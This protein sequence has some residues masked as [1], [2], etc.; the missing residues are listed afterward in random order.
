M[1]NPFNTTTQADEV[2]TQSTDVS[3]GNPFDTQLNDNVHRY[4]VDPI[5]AAASDVVGGA[6]ATVTDIGTSLWNS[7]PLTPNVSTQDVLS[8]VS[9][10]ALRVYNENPDTINTL[11]FIGG[12]LLPMS[13]ATKGMGAMRAGIKGVNW[14]SAAGREADLARVATLFDQA[15]ESTAEYRNLTRSIYAK[16]AVNQAIDA[17][18]AEAAFV[19]MYNAHP[20]MEDYLKDP[21]QNFTLS[22]LIGG[23]LGAGVGAIADRFVLKDITGSVAET[24]FNSVNEAMRAITPDMTN[25]VKLQSYDLNVKNLQDVIDARKE[26]G[27]DKFNDLTYQIADQVQNSI[28]AEQA[29]L[30]DEMVSP[31]IKALPKEERDVIMQKIIQSPEMFGADNFR[32]LTDKEITASGVVKPPKNQLE[33]QPSFV[34]NTS[35]KGPTV[36]VPK[37]AVYY[38][39]LGLYGTKQDAVHYAGASVFGKTKEQLAKELP[40][41]YGK[42]PNYDSNLELLA[43]GSADAQAEQIAAW[44]RVKQMSVKE[45]SKLNISETDAVLQNAVL[46]RLLT[47]PEAAGLAVRVSDNSPVLKKIIETHTERLV[48]DGKLSASEVAASGPDAAY[49]NKVRSF[50]DGDK[51]NTFRPSDPDALDQINRW[52]AGGGVQELR[53]ASVDYFAIKYGG[54]AKSGASTVAA[55]N[56]AKLYEAPESI[57]LRNKYRELADAGGN[58]YLYRGWKTND[59][60]GHAPVESYSAT[61]EKAKQFGHVK[62]Y[63]VNVDD[64]IAGFKDVGPGENNAEILVRAGAR[65]VE[66]HLDAK[67]LLAFKKAQQQEAGK[68]TT[69]TT[70]TISADSAGTS[71]VD[72]QGLSKIYIANKQDAID[73]LLNQGMPIQSIALKT[74]TDPDVVNAWAHARQN[75]DSLESLI[76]PNQSPISFLNKI[77][78]Y[79]DIDNVLKSSNQPIVMSGNLRKNAAYVDNHVALDKHEMRSLNREFLYRTMLSSNNS[80]VQAMAD[81]FYSPEGFGPALDVI[82]AKLGKVNNELAGNGFINSFDFF[83][84]NMAE[85]GPATSAIGKQIQNIANGYIKQVVAPI[86]NAMVA[87]QKDPAALVEFSVFHNL[88]ASLKG[89]RGFDKDGY[90]VQ[91]VEKQ[92]EDGTTGQVLERVK[93]QGNDYKVVTQEARDL[94]QAIQDQSAGLRDLSNTLRKATGAP[95]ISD[96]GLWIPSFNPVDKFIAYV[97]DTVT[98]TTKLL[99]GKTEAELDN[100]VKAYHGYLKETGQADTVRIISNKT[101]Q[102]NWNILNGR[103]DPI[104]MERA[105]IGLQKT[106][107]SAAAIVKPDIKLLGEIAAGYEHY[108]TAQ[109]RNLADI[110]MHEITEGLQR[111]SAYNKRNFTSQPLSDVKKAIQQPKDAAAIMRNVLLGSPNLGEYAGWQWLNKGFETTIAVA[112]NSLNQVWNSTVKP[113]TKGIFGGK[114]ELDLAGIKK[115]DFEEFTKELNSRGIQHPFQDFDR[116]AAEKLGFFNLEANPDT[117]KRVIFASNALAATMALRFAELAQPLVNAM[118]LPILT[119]L[120][121][122]QKM[123]DTF[124]GVQKATTKAWPSQIMYEGVRAMHSP[125]FADLNTKWEKLG[126]F[127][128][129]VSEATNVMRA[130]RRFEP[131]LI[132]KVENA[133]D[134]NIVKTMSKPSDYAESLTRKAAMNTGAVLAKRLYPELDD[135]GITIFARDFMD[136][137]IGNFHASQRPVMFQGTLG[138]G[139]GLF[140]TYMLTLAQSVYRHLELKNYKALG[141]A[142]LAQST[143]FGAKSM[144]GF[145]FVS[146]AIGD[147][148]SDD[149]VDLTTGTYRALPNKLADLTLYGLPSNLGPSFTSRGGVDFRP[150]NFTALQFLAQTYGLLDNTYKAVKLEN[151]NVGRAFLQAL[152]LQSMSRPLART[153]ELA[154]GYSLTQKGDTVQIPEEVWSY[155]GVAARLLATRPVEEQKLRDEMHLNSFYGALDR[156]HREEVMNKVRTA[157]RSGTLDDSKLSTYAEEYFRKGGSPSGWR[158]AINSAVA[159]TDAPGQDALIQK[160]RPDNPVNFMIDSLER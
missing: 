72:A 119:G 105:D 59:I 37:D 88:N 58:V 120:A 57:A 94:I 41:N 157:I 56:F 32:L 89:W 4:A 45:L 74:N 9:S 22:A 79:D 91:K 13:L 127:S 131:G 8:R 24:A 43:K 1:D 86:E 154:T 17:V 82:A 36:P 117:S 51:I 113:I 109:V 143:L 47:D 16:T 21:V 142:M 156:D 135:A 130:T 75:V 116:A 125:M 126:Y 145:N 99:W 48:Q 124:M 95:D 29:K 122:A 61:P 7:L 50:T 129:M 137:A 69:T 49:M 52:V 60:K 5:G 3:T 65:P 77:K 15:A 27:K 14:F 92:L 141:K 76:P 149:N 10:D 106:G 111:I 25:A 96:I 85:V 155:Q 42:I 80:A 153:S 39:E 140:Q 123:P 150:P 54:Y 73:S 147:H 138:V 121:I 100:S 33:A 139:L 133:L 26:L 83:A 81:A 64:I 12:M 11:S 2:P 115:I 68:I 28:K 34:S 30:F 136:K 70:T 134:S 101:E 144:P 44:E 18:A 146:E 128:P 160:L 118:S 98:D 38:P 103:L 6:V 114:K 90:L 97:H 20:Y 102:A 63:K 148:F 62:L 158:S 104:N 112:V 78:S 55:K 67:G 93:Y 35:S 40:F 108:I 46:H 152:S 71:L 151:E 107:S 23:G 53:K 31:G 159:R 84:R 19:A 66:A 110:N 132:S 87:V